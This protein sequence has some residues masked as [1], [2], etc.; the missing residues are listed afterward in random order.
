VAA[1][2]TREEATPVNEVMR[3]AGI[4]AGFGDEIPVGT[5]HSGDDIPPGTFH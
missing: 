3:P 5:F 4:M 1:V 2:I